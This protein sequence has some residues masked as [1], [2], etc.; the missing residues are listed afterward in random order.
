MKEKYLRS[1]SGVETLK[2]LAGTVGVGSFTVSSLAERT[3]VPRET[4]D[5][6]LRRHRH[7]FRKLDLIS[8]HGRGRP[9]QRWQLRAEAID[10]VV[11]EVGR[12]QA[13]IGTQ[14]V[15]PTTTSEYEVVEA[16]LTMATDSVLRAS[17]D[18]PQTALSLL[19]AAR[20]SIQAAGY[21]PVV[22]DIPGEGSTATDAFSR[23]ARVVSAVADLIEAQISGDAERIYSTQCKVLPLLRDAKSSMSAEEWLL[24]ADR[25]MGAEGNVSALPPELIGAQRGD[26]GH[27]IVGHAF[28]EEAQAA[29]R[30]REL[31]NVLAHLRAERGLSQSEVAMRMRASKL[32]VAGIESHQHDPQLS[33]LARYAT[34]LGVSLHFTLSEHVTGGRVWTSAQESERDILRSMRSLTGGKFTRPATLVSPSR[35]PAAR[36]FVLPPTVITVGERR[37]RLLGIRNEPESANLSPQ[38]GGLALSLEIEDR[39]EEQLTK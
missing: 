9:Q 5:T 22:S 13:V 31:I 19:K 23:R 28:E 25:V 12:L 36:P 18:E 24:L 6:V 2:V 26:R 29:N 34:A 32:V 35:T 27:G 21:D 33:I 38:F 30:N 14:S 16:S 37:W 39:L 8:R 7:A 3:G 11:A 20:S 15:E 1:V 4:V 17:A 10:E